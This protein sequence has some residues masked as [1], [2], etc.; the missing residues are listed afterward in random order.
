[1]IHT[2]RPKI[3]TQLTDRILFV[4]A[5]ENVKKKGGEKK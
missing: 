1:M 5:D 4:Q 3:A 2:A